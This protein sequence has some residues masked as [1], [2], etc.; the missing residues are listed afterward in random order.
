MSFAEN[1]YET[2]DRNIEGAA[3]IITIDSGETKKSTIL[4]IPSL[5]TNNRIIVQLQVCESGST[6][7]IVNYINYNAYTNEVLSTGNTQKGKRFFQY[8][9]NNNLMETRLEFEGVEK[10]KI[11]VKHTGIGSYPIKIGNYKA[12]FIQSTNAVSII[13]PILGEEFVITVL[14]G[15]PGRFNNYNLC[16]F[17]ESEISSLGDYVKSFTSISS[18]DITHYIDFDSFEYK[19]GDQ[20]DLL[21]YAVQSQNTKLEFLYTVISGVVGEIKNVFTPMRGTVQNNL[22]SQEFYKNQTN[23]LYY[24]F[25]GTPVGD[26][27]SLRIINEGETS[28]TVAKVIC[29]FVKKGLTDAEMLKIINEVPQTG[30]NLCKGDERKNPN[31]FDALINAR[32]VKKEN[33]RILMMIQYG[34]GENDLVKKENE[35]NNEEVKDESVLLK[36]NLRI[37]G[38]DVSENEK[39]FNEDETEA[40]VPY[41]LD[42]TKI[43]GQATDYISKVLI[44]SS[45]RELEMFHLENG[46]P[47]QLFTGN[48]LLVYT[49]PDVIKE[50]YL[51]ATTM[52]LLT[53]SLFKNKEIVIGES[54]RF[55]TYFF[56][57]DNTMNYYVSSNPSGRPIN[58]P[59]TMEMPDC[60]K[61][62]YYILNYHYIE[63]R[64]LTL[65]IDKIYGQISTKRIATELNK[66]DWYE[67]IESMDEFVEEE[68]LI[69]KKSK[70]HMD[71]IE[72]T[73][74]IPTL[75]HIY[76]T[77]DNKPIT[78]GI[79]PGDTSIINIGPSNTQEFKLQSNIK[80]GF[81]LVFSFNILS[82]D[83]E[84][85]IRIS[86]P[87]GEP[88]LA[89]RNGV[90]LK[91]TKVNFERINVKNEDRGGSSL[92]RII[93]KY[94][95]EIEDKFEPLENDI[96]HYNDTDNLYGYKFK[97]DDDWLN[98]TSVDF[99]VSTNEEN[100]K[101][102][103]STSFGSFMEPALQDCYRVGRAN[104][105][106]LNI[107][108]PYLMFKDYVTAGDEI[109]KYYVGFKTVDQNQKIE[110]KPTLNKYSTKLRNLENDPKSI[111]VNRNNNTILTA[112]NSPYVF[113]QMQV[114]DA[115][116][117]VEIDFF[118][119]YN[120]T[121]LKHRDMIDDNPYYLSIENTRLDTLLSLST[122]NTA[123]V[124]VRHSGIDE[125]YYPY[126]ED[127]VITFNKENNTIKLKQPI[128]EEEFIYTVYIDHKGTLKSKNYNL[129]SF[130]ENNKL[131]H[132]SKSVNSSDEDINIGIDFNLED[133][134]DYT[135]FDAMVLAKQINNGKIMILSNVIS[136]SANENNTTLI[137]VVI[138]LGVVLVGGGIA[139]YILL[140]RYKN[141]PNSKKLDAKQTS[142][143]MVDNEN[144]KMI[145]STATE[146]YD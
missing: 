131:A 141:K 146:R 107:I 133:L 72:A 28:V 143:A 127:L 35:E 45:K 43:R 109:M 142:L 85:N 140:K 82:E 95:Y 73:C 79:Q 20:F 69:N 75:L 50:K 112:P 27:A 138:V 145:Q 32:E 16:T 117:Y 53:E 44:Y 48:I 55:K 29:T 25:T 26:V 106:K 81:T 71:V 92:T 78:E 2:K 60:E 62:Y 108:N 34:F 10:D 93:F 136:V 70:Y 15:R 97:T 80:Q 102:C 101:F 65:H 130:A 113:I 24:D 31:G 134:Q 139:V 120:N 49:N 64:D 110:I 30:T 123:K 36:I 14:V 33:N 98:Y 115:N 100:V 94:G 8:E 7:G 54:F 23:Y 119:A 46:T 9:I 89:T 57:S 21:V 137:V 87:S 47:T 58:V 86:F 66:E 39:K 63:T 41:V 118:N 132:F 128:P 126:V 37:S 111:S 4:S 103:Y 42:L 6:L 17:M 40:L 84:P 1:K 96:Y 125:E 61:P 3:K 124:F 116:K 129:C 104:S 11:F 18:D 5:I 90:Y 22:I 135:D 12:T 52:I 74:L 88:I 144:E 59:T 105:Y 68:F 13:K 19:E 51:G 67:L 114:C 56:Q 121:S 99:L 122:D 83:R 91:T 77:D 38:F 76:Y